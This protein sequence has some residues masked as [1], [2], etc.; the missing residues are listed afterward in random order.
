MSAPAADVRDDGKRPSRALA[1]AKTALGFVLAQWLIMGF[2][3]A[4]VLAY[5]FPCESAALLSPVRRAS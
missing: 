4:C 5:F 2:G 1:R 3:V